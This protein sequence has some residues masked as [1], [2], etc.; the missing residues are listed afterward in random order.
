MRD[1]CPHVIR[2]S[3]GSFEALLHVLCLAPLSVRNSGTEWIIAIFNVR[4]HRLSVLNQ[5]SHH[6][7]RHPDCPF[8]PT[9]TVIGCSFPNC[10]MSLSF[11][12]EKLLFSFKPK[13]C[14]SDFL[15]VQKWDFDD[16]QCQTCARLLLIF[17]Q[18]Q[19]IYVCVCVRFIQ[20]T[21]N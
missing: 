16:Y 21:Q 3:A 6:P 13:S 17:L 5:T 12:D 9:Q 7:S 20:N 14:K 19:Y 18:R 10:L 8:Q 15:D 2:C 1:S 11:Q 4:L